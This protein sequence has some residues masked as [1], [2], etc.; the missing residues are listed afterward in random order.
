[1]ASSEGTSFA[2][3]AQNSQTTNC[4]RHPL[5]AHLTMVPA[6]SAHDAHMVALRRRAVGH[7]RHNG[8]FVTRA[9]YRPLQHRADFQPVAALHD[10]PVQTRRISG[11]V[12]RFPPGIERTS[13]IDDTIEAEHH[14]HRDPKRPAQA[15]GRHRGRAELETGV[16]RGPERG[17]SPAGGETEPGDWAP[18]RFVL[19]RFLLAM[20]CRSSQAIMTSI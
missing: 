18:E 9:A 8:R 17:A 16:G 15:K 11:A 2:S 6:V 20:A 10:A 7:G 3:Y 12:T 14:A 19:S 13:V 1:M 5:Q 4:R